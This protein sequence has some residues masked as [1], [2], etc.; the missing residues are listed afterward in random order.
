MKRY[1]LFRSVI[2]IGLFGSVAKPLQ[3]SDV[4]IYSITKG[5]YYQQTSAAAPLALTNNGYI[6]EADAFLT[7][8]GNVRS[9]FLQAPGS[10]NQAL[11]LDDPAQFQLKDKY[12]TK[13]K[14]DSHY[15]DG[16]FVLTLNTLHDG[17]GA[18]TLPLQGGSYP[19]APRISN[20]DATQWVNP[21]G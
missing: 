20:F 6:F 21:A 10:T 11:T 2:L 16:N 8:P 14:L 19:N 12:N 4:S 7:A 13:A 1:S 17:S 9:A 18:I 15:P 5:I 3:A